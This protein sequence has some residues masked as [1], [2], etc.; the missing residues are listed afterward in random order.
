MVGRESEVGLAVGDLREDLVEVV[1]GEGVEKPRTA[2]L[3]R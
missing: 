1:A 2:P 3:T